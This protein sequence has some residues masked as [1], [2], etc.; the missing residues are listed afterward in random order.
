LTDGA[1]PAAAAAAAAAA[2]DDDDDDDDDD[3]HAMISC[4]LIGIKTVKVRRNDHV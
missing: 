3:L 1:V 2:A 4:S